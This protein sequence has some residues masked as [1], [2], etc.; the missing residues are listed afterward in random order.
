MLQILFALLPLFTVMTAFVVGFAWYFARASLIPQQAPNTQK[1]E[2][3]Y[4]PFVVTHDGLALNGWFIPAA[5]AAAGTR[6][7]VILSHG[8]GGSAERMLPHADYLHKAGF[9]CVLYDLR[10]HGDSGT[11]EVATLAAMVSDL[12]A[13]FAAVVQRPEVAPD[14]VG[15]FGHSMGGAISLLAAASDLPIRAVVSSS[16]FADLDDL[17]SLMLHSRH[18]PDFLFKRLVEK[19]WQRDAGVPLE[20]INPVRQV[21]RIRFPVLLLHG[22]QD[23]VIPSEQMEKLH[24]FA[25]KAEKYVVKGRGHSDLYEDPVYRRKVIDYFEAR[26]NEQ[27]AKNE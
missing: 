19:F 1:P 4:E 9:H 26:F 17:I 15:L 21:D 5:G 8:W 6:P 7:T 10:G 11:V 23:P 12:R 25:L 18:L 16:G 22:E 20:R 14:Q 27:V 2:M 3:A 24:G 13:V